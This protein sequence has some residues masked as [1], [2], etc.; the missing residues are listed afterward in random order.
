MQVLSIRAT[1]CCSTDD[2]D[3]IACTETAFHIEF[4]RASSSI[5]VFTS[6]RLGLLCVEKLRAFFC[7]PK[8]TAA[9]GLSARPTLTIRYHCCWVAS[10]NCRRLSLEDPFFTQDRFFFGRRKRS[11]ERRTPL[12]REPGINGSHFQARAELGAGD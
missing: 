4:R 6:C 11:K 10:P 2:G 8:R 5:F 7:V 9:L 3:G 12:K 1:L